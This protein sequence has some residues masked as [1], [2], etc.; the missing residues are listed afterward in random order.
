MRIPALALVASA[1]CAASSCTPASPAETAAVQARQ[2]AQ[3]ATLTAGKVP[4]APINCL[5]TYRANDMVVVNDNTV[6]FKQGRRL[7]VNNMQGSCYGLERGTT[8]LVTRTPSTQLCRGDIATLVDTSTRTSVGSCVFGDFVPYT[9][10]GMR[11]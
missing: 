6:A 10:T 9:P 8:A 5:A 4:G 3:F 11:Y 1:A 7:Y 2:Q